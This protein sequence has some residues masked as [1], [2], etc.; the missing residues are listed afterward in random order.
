MR[1]PGCGPLILLL[2]PPVLAGCGTVGKV[3]GPSAGGSDRWVQTSGPS[4]GLWT[5]VAPSLTTLI[6]TS[7]SHGIVR[8]VD[9]GA[10][11]TT[12]RAEPAAF[13]V[14]SPAGVFAGT[15]S[16]VI[17]STD[18]GVTWTAVNMEIGRAHV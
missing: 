11:W 3:A 2:I 7:S 6:A 14:A 17:R 18:D 4:T 8:S 12:V 10:S 5:V 13:L 1:V 15:A 9:H 16:G